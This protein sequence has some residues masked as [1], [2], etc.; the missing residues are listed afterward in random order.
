MKTKKRMVI[1]LSAVLVLVVAL[2]AALLPGIFRRASYD[3]TVFGKT[4]GFDSYVCSGYYSYYGPDHSYSLAEN[5]CLYQSTDGKEAAAK[6]SDA[7]VSIQL[8]PENFDSKCVG[9][10]WAGDGMDAQHVREHTEK[11]WCAAG[12][13][14]HIYYVLLQDNGDV[15]LCIGEGSQNMFGKPQVTEI[16]DVLLLKKLG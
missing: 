9:D 16:G 14:G 3:A 2:S 13:N 8:T 12:E 11:A 4:Y 7:M 5:G 6:I 15:F 1:V 10:S